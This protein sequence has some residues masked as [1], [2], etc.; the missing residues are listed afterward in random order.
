MEANLDVVTG[1]VNSL[2]ASLAMGGGEAGGASQAQAQNIAEMKAQMGVM[3]A[4]NRYAGSCHCIHVTYL[5]DRLTDLEET[6]NNSRTTG[7]PPAASAWCLGW[8]RSPGRRGYAC[9]SINRRLAGDIAAVSSTCRGVAEA[10][11]T[12]MKDCRD[13]IYAEKENAPNVAEDKLLNV[14]AEIGK[15]QAAATA[16]QQA[17]EEMCAYLGSIVGERP[18]EGKAIKGGFEYFASEIHVLKVA[19]ERLRS[20]GPHSMQA[21]SSA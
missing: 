15:L 6:M 2:A 1:Q 14:A 5:N 13:M 3:T 4:G 16:Q 19:V 10:H 11:R 7:M 17:S 12:E 8:F 20:A 21:S 18:A 9:R